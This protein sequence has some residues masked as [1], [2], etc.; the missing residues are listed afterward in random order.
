MTNKHTGMIVL[1]ITN[2]SLLMLFLYRQMNLKE[3]QIKLEHRF[4]VRLKYNF[5][6][7]IP[8]IDYAQ[9][10]DHKPHLPNQSKNLKTV[11]CINAKPKNSRQKLNSLKLCLPLLREHVPKKILELQKYI[12]DIPN[13]VAKYGEA[14]AVKMNYPFDQIKWLD[15]HKNTFKSV[16][17]LNK[18][19]F[20]RNPIDPELY[21]D[22]PDE[23]PDFEQPSFGIFNID[24]Y[25]D[26]HDVLIQ[27]DTSLALN[28]KYFITDY[29]QMGLPRLFVMNRMGE[30]L[31]PKISKNMPRINYFQKLY[32]IDLRA[33]M[34]YFKTSSFH[35]QHK[36][37]KHF[38]CFGQ[39][40]NHIPGHGAL[41]RKDLLNEFTKN[42][43]AKF[44][45]NKS[46]KS[47]MDFFLSGF[48][49]YNE[50]EC[51]DF[52]KIINTNEYFAKKVKSPFQ[53]IIKIGH[54]VHRGAGVYL[55]N[56]TFEDEIKIL[57]GNGD[58]CGQLAENILAQ[59]Y[60]DNPVLFKKHKFDFRVYMLI[61][62]VAPYRIYYHEGFLRVSLF[63]FSKQST[64]MGAQITNTEIAKALI[65]NLTKYNETHIGMTVEQLREFQMQTLEQLGDYLY[66]IGKVK[67]KN[68]TQNYLIKQ[69]KR[70]FLS[71]GK[72]IQKR[73]HKSADLFETFGVDFV[74]DEDLKIS[75]IEVNASPM[76]VG[77]NKRKTKL[78]MDMMVGLFNIT[79][80]Q[81]F[82]RTERGLK[83]IEEN[84]NDIMNSL[85]EEL[86]KHQEAFK[87]LYVNKVDKK[88]EEMF[89]NNPWKLVY[90]ESLEGSAKYAGLL[91]D[92]CAEFVDKID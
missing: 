51:R 53:F 46:C 8:V 3:S 29:H 65:K 2:F 89:V 17:I 61:S 12:K 26:I 14:G 68:W 19:N 64:E 66:S 72:M 31:M 85:P 48:R 82:S 15:L 47:Q 6:D 24:E 45:S 91:T 77:T 42:W 41:I 78:M 43:M 75:V 79:F 18:L 76:V 37:G 52:F 62:S 7:L 9:T 88:Y 83:Y 80:A 90:D 74:I 57:Y 86:L 4:Q 69:F 23:K 16:N 84:R 39:S 33:N 21:D 25:C 22:N 59:T 92:D 67:D 54:G 1:L 70:A 63:E 73:V 56:G 20:Y 13:Y 55:F 49:L 30:D 5:D 36:I 71:L 44:D 27:Q 58:K 38:G 50:Q 87:K 10:D 32:P 28:K 81:Q 34:F 11:S 35:Y 60:V 40:Y